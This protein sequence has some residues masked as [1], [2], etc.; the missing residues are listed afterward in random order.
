MRVRAI[1][2]VRTLVLAAAALLAGC[3]DQDPFGASSHGVMGGYA[4]EKFESGEYYL[5]GR[6]T[7]IEE[8]GA[9]DGMVER[10]GWN[11]RYILASRRSTPGGDPDGW[12]IV[13][14]RT[15]AVSGP[16]TD[17]VMSADRRV[18]GIRPLPAFQAWEQLGGTM[19]AFL[20][21]FVVP[22]GVVVLG[23]VGLSGRQRRREPGR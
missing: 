3:V 18:R 20:L 6:G 7:R 13:D 17:A 14:V 22:L 23:I 19:D 10:I 16:L 21:R 8:G 2:I 1:R 11:E 15:G 12:M 4:L 9:L 5:L